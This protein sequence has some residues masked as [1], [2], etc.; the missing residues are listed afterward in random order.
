VAYVL[1]LIGDCKTSLIVAILL[2]YATIR[3]GRGSAKAW[4]SCNLGLTPYCSAPVSLARSR[5]CEWG[6]DEMKGHKRFAHGIHMWDDGGENKAV[7]PA[8]RIRAIT[9]F[10]RPEQRRREAKEEWADG[11]LHRTD[12]GRAR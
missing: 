8:L 4:R 11:G 7:Q 9:Y 1:S 6:R 3:T 2:I 12:V 10:G 5:L